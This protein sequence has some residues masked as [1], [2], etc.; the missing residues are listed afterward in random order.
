MAIERTTNC[1]ESCSS[2]FGII[3]TQGI[4]DLDRIYL[5]SL[6]D[7]NDFYLAYVP[8]TFVMEAK[9]PFDLAYMKTLYD[10]GYAAAKQGYPWARKPV[11]FEV[12]KLVISET[13]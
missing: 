10:I 11:G 5:T 2:Q 12:E 13:D 7:G 9:E 1:D 3:R 6:R 8:E 4:G